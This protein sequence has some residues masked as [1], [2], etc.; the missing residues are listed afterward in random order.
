MAKAVGI[1]FGSKHSGLTAVAIFD[2]GTYI[3]HQ[4]PI[5]KDTDQWLISLL[6]EPEMQYLIGIDAPLSLPGVYRGLEGFSDYHYR[7]CDREASAMSPMFI[8]GLT[9]RA[10]HIKE[11]LEE[12]SH[13]VIEVYPKQVALR[14][15]L[16]MKRYKK[17][18]TYIND[19]HEKIM[20]LMNIE[21]PKPENWHQADALLALVAVLNFKNNDPQF[22]GNDLEGIM[23]F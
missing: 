20:N 6:N 1:D 10:I 17:D 2:A 3:I 22:F 7:K 8:G 19:V 21:G 4:V 11:K 13:Q 16:N 23:Y 14:I 5:K 15:N 18:P 9:A 12:K